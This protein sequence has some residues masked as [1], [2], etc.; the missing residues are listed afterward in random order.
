MDRRRRPGARRWGAWLAGWDPAGRPFP[1]TG[2]PEFNNVRVIDEDR[3]G[4]LW[5][6]AWGGLFR[7]VAANWERMPADSLLAG[8]YV[9]SIEETHTGLWMGTNGSG[10]LHWDGSVFSRIDT[11][12]GLS[13][14]NV[15]GITEDSHGIL[16]VGTE[17]L[18]LNRIDPA[19]PRNPRITAIREEHGL[20]DNA[21][22]EALEDG[23][24]RLW[25]SSNR[26]IFWILRSELEA[27]ARGERARV[28]SVAYTERH[29]LKNREANG[30]S[31]P[32]AL[33]DSRGQLWFVTVD[34]VAIVDPATV[35]LGD[36]PPPIVIEEVRAAGSRY[37]VRDRPVGLPSGARSL[38]VDFTAMSFRAPESIEFRYRLDGVDD[39]WVEVGNRRVAYYTRVPPGN[40]RFRVQAS[41]GPASWGDEARVMLAVPARP[42]E[43]WWFR[44]LLL[45]LAGG[46]LY[47]LYAYRMRI[48]RMQLAEVT[49]EAERRRRVEVDLRRLGQRLISAQEDE[50]RRLSR[51]L[52][53]DVSQ[54]LALLN[55]EVSMLGQTSGQDVTELE[56]LAG[57]L[58]DDLRRISHN[59]HPGKLEQVGIVTGLS[60]LC[61]ELTRR[62]EMDVTFRD[63]TQDDLDLSTD[64][65]LCMYRVAQEALHN[66]WKHSGAGAA[67]VTLRRA[68]GGVELV[69][70]DEGRGFDFLDDTRGGLGLLSMSERA[71]AAGV[72]LRIDSAPGQGTRIHLRLPS[73]LV[74]SSL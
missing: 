19:D 72:D 67:T 3:H 54:R 23:Q 59:L 30:G 48:Q 69:V 68:A 36:P 43:T 15:R 49:A 56:R 66:S 40:R 47:G 63:E 27:F 32:N 62:T 25:L 12:Q 31:Q 2:L 8:A 18:G 22:H 52:H 55:I 33:C 29:G 70:A 34:G 26:G 51:E 35:P 17:G 46:T 73:R 39:D 9:R 10:I 50:R 71:R 65:S 7:R 11:T 61:R 21:V 28:A 58:A 74:D 64:L 57:E 53:D 16:W 14:M 42:H 1:Q 5:V 41:R 24:G 4:A 44:G 37:P 6:G 13:G 38:E 60:S 45:A 20:Y